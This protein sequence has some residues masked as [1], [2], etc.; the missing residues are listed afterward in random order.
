MFAIGNTVSADP[1]PNP[2]AVSPAARPRRS[3][4]HLSALPT[5]APYTAPAPMP[6][7]I[8]PAYSI[9]SDVATELI[10]QAAA[11]STPAATPTNRGPKRSTRY[12]SIGTSHVS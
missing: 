9:G 10:T 4:N 5:H 8:A 12:P 2:I 11:T 6:P 7:T 3:G 1:A